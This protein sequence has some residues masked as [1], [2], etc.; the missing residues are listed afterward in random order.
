MTPQYTYD[1]NGNPVGVFIPIKDWNNLT[2]KH[3]GIEELAQWEKDLIDQRLGYA[4]Q[5][6]DTFI[7]VAHF[8]TQL[9]EQDEL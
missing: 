1:N 4:R 8:M 5:H 2:E 7:P 3:V 9:D 6:P